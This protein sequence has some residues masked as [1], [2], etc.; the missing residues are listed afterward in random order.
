[1]WKGGEEWVLSTVRVLWLVG[2]ACVVF[3]CVFHVVV[4][5]DVAFFFCCFCC[6]DD[7]GVIVL[8]V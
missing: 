6:F 5:V 2:S 4:Q 7:D 8:L 3:G 1:M